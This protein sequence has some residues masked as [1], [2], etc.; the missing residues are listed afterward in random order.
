[1][2]V[3]ETVTE[4]WLQRLGGSIKA[5]LFG[6]LLFA[7]G[8]PVLFLNEG[9]YV[10]TAKALDEGQGACVSLDTC[11]E[12]DPE[13]NGRLVHA[14]GKA[15][16]D[17]VLV[18]DVFG[19]SVNAISLKRNVEMYQWVEESHTTEKKKLGGKLEKTT[20][21]TYKKDWVSQAIDSSGFKESG[22]DNPAS[23]EFAGDGPLY[24]SNVRLGAFRLN[25]SQVRRIGGSAAYKFPESFT[26]SVERVQVQGSVIYVPNAETRGNPLNNRVV[27]SQPRIGDMRVTFDVVVPHAVSVVAKQRDDS[28][29]GYVAKTGKKVDLLADGEK[30]A[31]EMFADAR[32]ANKFLTWM[33]RLVGF[34]MMFYGLSTVLKPLSVLADVLPILGD[35]VGIGTG[36][37][38]F[39]V[40]LVCA[41]VTIAVAWVFYRPVVA[42]IVLAVAAFFAWRLFQRRR[43][44]RAAQT[45]KA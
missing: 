20:T 14:T 41:L 34:A 17:D 7:G 3:T 44:V 35:I 36:I 9:R 10:D 13:M 4:G 15:E 28:F 39:L 30:D 37:V 29:V 38:A 40:A 18:D 24:A 21:Y 27:A 23:M 1:M 11:A 2:A 19:V 5:M 32:S 22:H 43:A 42:G 45:A 8:F 31:A 26:S 6:V 33:L 12:I 16:T 25:E